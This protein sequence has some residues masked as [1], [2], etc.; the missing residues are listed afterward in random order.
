[1]RDGLWGTSGAYFHWFAL[2][3]TEEGELEGMDDGVVQTRDYHG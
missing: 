2:V 1:M 3:Q